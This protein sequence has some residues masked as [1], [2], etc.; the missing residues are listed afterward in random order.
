MITAAKSYLDGIVHHDGSRVLFA[1]NVRRTTIGYSHGQVKADRIGGA[2]T[3]EKALRNSIGKEVDMLPH[4]NTRFFVDEK[5]KTVIAY[6]LLPVLATNADSKRPSHRRPDVGDGPQPMTIH[7]A[8][9]YKIEKGLI[10]EV[11][12]IFY[13]EFGTLDGISG[14]PDR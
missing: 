13:Q 3:G 12:G 5:N 11:E 14:W 8:E 7:L 1:P 4:R 2:I 6:T 9:R 10:T